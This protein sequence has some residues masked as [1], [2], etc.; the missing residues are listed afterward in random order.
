MMEFLRKH[1]EKIV[2]CLVLLGVA[3]AVVW[4]RLNR[5]K[6]QE[7]LTQPLNVAEPKT[8]PEKPF[9]WGPY[10]QAIQQIGKPPPVNLS[11]AHNLFNPVI[12]KRKGD[13]LFKILQTGPDALVLLD[14]IPLYT[15]ISYERPTDAPIYVMS[16][17]QHVDLRQPLKAVKVEFVKKNEKTKSGLFIVRG[18]KGAENDPEAINLEITQSGDTNAWVSTN[19]PYKLVD[20]YIADLKYSP[21]PSVP[22]LKR[23]VGDKFNLDNE[24]YKIVEITNGAVRVENMHTTKQTEVRAKPA[25][26]DK[27]K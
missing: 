5:A 17:Q 12:W 24:W 8:A 4:M 2:L 16:A 7:E 18:I 3:A 23:H 22:L 10:Q 11:G 1:Y 25:Q 20:G 27:A 14:T 6:I 13:E 15:I 19:A 21:D 26:N 9:D